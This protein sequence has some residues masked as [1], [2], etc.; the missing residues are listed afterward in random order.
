[1]IITLATS[2][3]WPQK[4]IIIIIIIIMLKYKFYIKYKLK[5]DHIGTTKNHNNAHPQHMVF[6][7]KS[8]SISLYKGDNWFLQCSSKE[9]LS[10]DRERERERE[11]ERA[12]YTH[13]QQRD[14]TG[15]ILVWGSLS[16][17]VRGFCGS[18]CNG[19]FDYGV[20]I[21]TCFS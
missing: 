16:D 10:A 13:T 19:E 11:R 9:V 1:M 7:I 15:Y 14:E 5:I 17:E 20:E 18:G 2:S 21:W 4:H 12:S 3:N 8:F 6:F